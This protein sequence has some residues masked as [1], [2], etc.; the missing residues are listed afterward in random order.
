MNKTKTCPQCLTVVEEELNL[1][2]LTSLCTI[3]GTRSVSIEI[4]ERYFEVPSWRRVFKKGHGLIKSR[5]QACGKKPCHLRALNLNTDQGE[6]EIDICYPCGQVWFD[7]HELEIAAKENRTGFDQKIPPALLEELKNIQ[8]VDGT[9][10]PQ[11]TVFRFSSTDFQV[12][13]LH[14]AFQRLGWRMV[15]AFFG[16]PVEQQNRLR[17]TPW[18]TYGLTALVTVVSLFCFYAAPDLAVVLGYVPA[19]P[20]RWAGLPIFT[21]FL[22]HADYGHLLGNLYMFYI[23]GD[24]VEDQLGAQFLG[25]I[26][27]GTVLGVLFHHVT[28]HS[29]EIPLVGAS[30][31]ISAVVT[32]YALAFP[33]AQFNLLLGFILWVRIPVFFYVLFWVGL[34]VVGA[35]TVSD[36]MVATSFGGHLGG[37]LAGLLFWFAHRWSRKRG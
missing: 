20:L 17:G 15:L 24:N 3:C 11:H 8:V 35:L 16:L 25:L 4:I 29:P 21:S 18:L 31:G 23:F 36:E 1:E 37:A 27:A 22:V 34:Q 13:L 6:V 7:H 12:K 5:K 26:L 19:T 2:R 32:F 9:A 28:T 14:R 30:T 33:R 10:V